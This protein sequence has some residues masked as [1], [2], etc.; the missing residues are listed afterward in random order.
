MRVEF[1][2][3]GFPISLKQTERAKIKSTDGL[4]SQNQNQLSSNDT[5]EDEAED[6]AQDEAQDDDV[7]ARIF[8]IG[9]I[10]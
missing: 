9:K 8:R 2:F 7:C 4:S 6:E 1:L 10:I 5:A 3:L